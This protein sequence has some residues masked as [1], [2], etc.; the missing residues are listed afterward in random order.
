M[1][2]HLKMARKLDDLAG[3][4]FGDFTKCEGDDS[5]DVWRII[6]ELFHDAPYP[7]VK[8][9]AADHEQENLTLP[10]GVKMI[11]DGNAGVLSLIESPVA[12]STLL[13]FCFKLQTQYHCAANRSLCR[14]IDLKSHGRSRVLLT[15]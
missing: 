6:F 3:V 2:T 4:V 8:G 15:Y 10:F 13:I 1:L 11:L 5:R 14:L 9:M 7:V 12:Y